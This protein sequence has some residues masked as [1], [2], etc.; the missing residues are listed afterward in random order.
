MPSTNVLARDSSR[1]EDW[2]NLVLGG[3]LFI[4]PWAFQFTGV[5]TA[6]WNAWIFG[7]ALVAVAAAALMRVQKWEEWTNL[8]IGA[9]LVVAPWVLGF[10]GAATAMWNAVIVGIWLP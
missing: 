10:S 6:A 4:S 5:T 2:T 1:W 9:W 7:V 8:V 3:W